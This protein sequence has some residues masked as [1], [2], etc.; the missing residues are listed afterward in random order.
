M[1]SQRQS[2]DNLTTQDAVAK[3]VIQ[4]SMQAYS[5]AATWLAHLQVYSSPLLSSNTNVAVA[6]LIFCPGWL[7]SI[8]HNIGPEPIHGDWDVQMC[9]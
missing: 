1:L 8:Q 9:V 3:V 5:A 6:P 2:Q 4:E 7:F